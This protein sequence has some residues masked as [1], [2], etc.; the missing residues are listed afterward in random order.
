MESNSS[1]AEDSTVDI[2]PYRKKRNPS[3]GIQSQNRN[4]SIKWCMQNAHKRR[5]TSY[6]AS[7]GG[8]VQS[9][10][11]PFEKRAFMSERNCVL[12]RAYHRRRFNPNV[13]IP[14]RGHHKLCALNNVTKGQLSERSIEVLQY[15]EK[16]VELNTAPPALDGPTLGTTAQQK[17]GFLH[18]NVSVSPNDDSPID[19]SDDG[20]KTVLGET[21]NSQTLLATE[22]RKCVDAL[23]TKLGGAPSVKE[24]IMAV[25]REIFESMNIK[26]SRTPGEMPTETDHFVQ[27]MAV[28]RKYFAPGQ[29]IFTFPQ[30]VSTEAPSPYYHMIEGCCIGDV[31]WERSHLGV[32]LACPSCNNGNPIQRAY[33]NL[34]KNSILLNVHTYKSANLCMLTR[35]MHYRCLRCKEV[36]SGVDGRLL[37]KLPAHARAA[38]PVSPEY[39]IGKNTSFQVAQDVADDLRE[40]IK[41]Y[42]N[43]QQFTAKLYRRQGLEFER[44]A[45]TYV[46]VNANQERTDFVSWANWINGFYPPSP[47]S[48]KNHYQ[49]SEESTLG[50]TGMSNDERYTRELQSVTTTEGAAFDWTFA[51]LHNYYRSKAKACCTAKTS[52]GLWAGAVLVPST[53]ISDAAH[54]IEQMA[55]RPG[56]SLRVLYTDTWPSNNQFWFGIFGADLLGRLGLFHFLKR[57]LEFLDPQCEIYWKALDAFKSTIYRYNPTDYNSLIQVLQNGTMSHAAKPMS[58]PQIVDLRESKNWKHRTS[59]FLRK[60]LYQSANISFNWAKWN[61]DYLR[62]IDS[63][64][65]VLVKDKEGFKKAEQE[66]LNKTVRYIQDPENMEMYVSIPP[67]P[68]STHGLSSFKSKRCESALENGHLKL[69]HYANNGSSEVMADL[70]SMRGITEDNVKILHELARYEEKQVVSDPNVK[71]YLEDVSPFQNHLLLGHINQSHAAVGLKEP[72]RCPTVLGPDTGEVFLGRY[73]HQ[74]LKRNDRGEYSSTDRR[75]TCQKCLRSGIPLPNQSGEG[76]RQPQPLPPA[77]VAPRPLVLALPAPAPLQVEPRLLLPAPPAPVPRLIL[78]ALAPQQMVPR[79]LVPVM[80]M[81][82]MWHPAY[83]VN[84]A[85]NAYSNACCT[86]NLRWTLNDRRMGRPPHDLNCKNHPRNKKK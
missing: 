26:R 59:R 24:V 52:M 41:T 63:Q 29:I 70:L 19:F 6:N 20:S 85:S 69:A 83:Q 84:L 82:M 71:G 16:M 80:P 12:C 21:C 25:S 62:Y 18:P 56:F 28:Y 15:A 44:K 49:H 50:P 8:W 30:E 48:F 39:G 60:I 72:F 67:G 57:L 42:S 81:D 74:Q 77:Q 46:S 23:V 33:T 3:M 78:P 73:I 4:G 68:N 14:H 22:L 27:K 2:N 31:D 45:A 17:D 76:Q 40:S 86:R 38:Y 55:R 10:I 66:Q 75:C 58:D 54:F 51:V 53:K 47:D 65:R 35:V 11:S 43:P 5:K 61:C 64:G 79:Q 36:I 13:R 34:S 1:A 9:S 32:K 7:K 37:A